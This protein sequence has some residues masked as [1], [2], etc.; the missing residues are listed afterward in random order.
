MCIK[1]SYLT[2]DRDTCEKNVKQKLERGMK[3]EGNLCWRDFID[4][5]IKKE[6]NIEK[7]K[8]QF[9]TNAKQ[10]KSLEY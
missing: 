6:L 4:A 5:D 7:I 3:L 1:L 8:K 9:I 2:I 10:W